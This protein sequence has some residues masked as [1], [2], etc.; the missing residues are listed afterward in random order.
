MKNIQRFV[1]IATS[2]LMYIPEIAAK[3]TKAHNTNSI[4][5]LN[6]AEQPIYD[7]ASYHLL[8]KNAQA[9]D[10]SDIQTDLVSDF[11]DRKMAIKKHKSELENLTLPIN[12]KN[13]TVEQARASYL[14][15]QGVTPSLVFKEIG[16]APLTHDQKVEKLD[17]DRL[18]K[19]N[20][21]RYAQDLTDAKLSLDELDHFATLS[22]SDQEAVLKEGYIL[23]R[24]RAQHED[25]MLAKTQYRSDLA[26][27][28]NKT[29]SNAFVT[30]KKMQNEIKSNKSEIKKLQQKLE[31]LK[32]NNPE[33]QQLSEQINNLSQRNSINEDSINKS[34]A[35]L[36]REL[37]QMDEQIR[38]RWNL[39]IGHYQN[40]DLNLQ[41]SVKNILLSQGRVLKFNVPTKIDENPKIQNVKFD[42][43]G[44]ITELID[45]QMQFKPTIATNEL[46]TLPNL[47]AHTQAVQQ[48]LKAAKKNNQ[49]GPVQ[50]LTGQLA[51][52][53]Q[54]QA[55]AESL[56]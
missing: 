47:D 42:K 2:T 43:N 26:Q 21:K 30:I 14:A 27:F 12:P 44:A 23:P 33:Y 6:N 20:L 3:H 40:K 16:Q 41:D 19:R 53:Q 17:K 37:N 9:V 8:R 15:S 7:L 1:L 35:L 49:Q 13:T 52:L 4:E 51:Q 34:F 54:A 46:A 39:I 18:L 36:D 56:K 55:I 29:Q 28:V 24:N 5:D 11:E 10:V 50:Y 22:I 32:S 25:L 38:K 31:K 48:A 45:E